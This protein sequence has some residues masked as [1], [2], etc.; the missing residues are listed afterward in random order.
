MRT[1]LLH[2]SSSSTR[3][4]SSYV[5][6]DWDVA[7]DNA[8]CLS[9]RAS[10]KSFVAD[11]DGARRPRLAVYSRVSL[12]L[13]NSGSVARDHLASE[14]TFL[15]YVRTS[16]TIASAAVALAQLLTMSEGFKNELLAPLQPFDMYARPLAVL[17]IIFALYVLFVGVSRYF[18]VQSALTRGKFPVTRF[19]A[20]IIALGFATIICVALGL[21]L[22]EQKKT[23]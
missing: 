16:L 3:S 20:G 10:Y 12:V 4:I 14:R 17:S 21:L 8:R 2:G 15:A 23:G 6:D 22:A 11:I 1:P 13:E 18:S 7:Q 5:A 9:R 19:R